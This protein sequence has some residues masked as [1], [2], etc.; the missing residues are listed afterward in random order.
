MVKKKSH[1]ANISCFVSENKVRKTWI[2]IYGTESM[3]GSNKQNAHYLSVIHNFILKNQQNFILST[4]FHFTNNKKL[5]FSRSFRIG[6]VRTDIFVGLLTVDVG[7][8]FI[9]IQLF[10]YHYFLEPHKLQTGK[11]MYSSFSLIYSSLSNST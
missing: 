3:L 4:E 1:D 6:S 9:D 10:G 5:C 8:E 11:Q 2:R 7:S